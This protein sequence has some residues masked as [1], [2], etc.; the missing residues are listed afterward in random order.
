MSAKLFER[1][2]SRTFFILDHKLLRP[3]A[4]RLIETFL[5]AQDESNLLYDQ[6]V[7]DFMKAFN[8]WLSKEKLSED[9]P[10]FKDL[11][12][13][14]I[15]FLSEDGHPAL[16]VYSNYAGKP[17]AGFRNDPVKVH[18][19]VVNKLRNFL[20]KKIGEDNFLEKEV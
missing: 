17:D 19:N 5:E 13:T 3:H 4:E 14:R 16:H 18:E 12:T 9:A 11:Q 20:K 1:P 10:R 15:L 7:V 6:E 2:P 8:K